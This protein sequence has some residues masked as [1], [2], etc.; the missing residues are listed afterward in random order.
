MA[1]RQAAFELAALD[2]ALA[3]HQ[4]RQCNRTDV[5]ELL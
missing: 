1:L 5:G 2:V 3:K 4:A